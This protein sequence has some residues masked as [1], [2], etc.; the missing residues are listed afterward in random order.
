MSDHFDSRALR[1][2]DCYGQRFMRP[3]TYAYAIGHAGTAALAQDHPYVV[4]VEGDAPKRGEMAQTLV[5]VHAEG[6]AFVPDAP[7]VTVN[8]G[9]MVMWHCPDPHARPF[10]VSGEKDF[11]SSDRLVNESG[12]SH[13]FT[14]TGTYEWADAHGSG[15]KGVVRVSAPDSSSDKGIRAWQ[16]QQRQGVLVM[17]KDGQAE[18]AEVDVVLGQT[19]FFAVVAGPGISVTDTAVLEAERPVPGIAFYR[20]PTRGKD[21]VA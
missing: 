19:V 5:T 3:G 10:A 12:Y 21:A 1:Q 2:T 18:P 8:A 4:V 6:K 13:A 9:D 14:C 20:K 15:A 7:K 16:S 11:F 17:V